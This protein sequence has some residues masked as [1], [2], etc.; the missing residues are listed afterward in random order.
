VA[1][2]TTGQQ[3]ADAIRTEAARLFATQ[4]YAGTSLRDVASK[5]GIKVGSLYNHISSKQE[6]LFSVMGHTMDD[7]EAAMEEAVASRE[8]TLG[9]LTA[10]VELHIRFH[11]ERAQEVF[12]GNSEL[13]S[14]DETSRR[15]ITEKRKRYR[16]QLEGLILQAGEERS[17]EIVNA[18]L[19]AYSIVAMG[20][21]VAGWYR[22]DGPMSLDEIVS[23]YTTITLRSLN[24]A[25]A[26]A[27]VDS[28]LNS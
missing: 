7:L 15:E 14:L 20:T 19:H 2:M 23:S 13:R 18:K 27:L 11:A 10:F 4:G 12:I 16:S 5:V 26:D 21:H 1:T 24:V 6:L 22:P 8:D 17:A 9:K 28:I 3:T 25:D